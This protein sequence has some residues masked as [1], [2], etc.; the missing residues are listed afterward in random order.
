M[1]ARF[2]SVACPGDGSQALIDDG[3]I[4]V[5]GEV[6]AGGSQPD[7]LISDQLAASLPTD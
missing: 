7:G 2:G 3:R 5:P 1:P 6:L 4:V